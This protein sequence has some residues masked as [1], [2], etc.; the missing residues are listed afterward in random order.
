MVSWR[1]RRLSS[2][3]SFLVA[4]LYFKG[5][6]EVSRSRKIGIGCWALASVLSLLTAYARTFELEK[7]FGVD[8]YIYAIVAIVLA[9]VGL[10]KTFE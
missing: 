7:L 10:H 8:P 6:G 5:G 3:L 1:H 2:L 4:P 9:G